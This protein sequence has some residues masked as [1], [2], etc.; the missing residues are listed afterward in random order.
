[1]ARASLLMIKPNNYFLN[2]LIYI[3]KYDGGLNKGKCGPGAG[4]RTRI[5]WMVG[6]GKFLQFVIK[7]GR[8]RV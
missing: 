3:F 4:G 8:A 1:M 5:G 6:S 7:T 2:F